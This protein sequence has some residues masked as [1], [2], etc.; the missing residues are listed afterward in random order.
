MSD[1]VTQ[2]SLTRSERLDR[3]P[4]TRKHGKLLVGWGW[5]GRSARWTSG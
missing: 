5:A 2:T 4:F 3:L 1:A